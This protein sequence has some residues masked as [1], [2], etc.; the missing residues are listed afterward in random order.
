MKRSTQTILTLSLA[1]L[2]A[3]IQARADCQ[4]VAG[5]MT[6]T[7]I[8]APND[9]YGRAL[10]NVTGVLNGVST[11]VVTSPDGS[12]SSDVIVTNRGDMLTGNGALTLTPV[13]G[14]SDEFTLHVILTITGGSGKYS[15]ATGKLTYMGLARFTSPTTGTFD[16]IYRGSVCTP[17]GKS[18]GN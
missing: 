17:N 15:G 2:G 4:N 11:A 14:S 10:G 1:V 9:P 3:A 13:P 16:V 8:P 12:T 6:E 7:I 18:G 5:S